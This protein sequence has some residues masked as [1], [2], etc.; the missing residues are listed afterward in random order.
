MQQ[1]QQYTNDSDWQQDVRPS[2][3]AYHTEPS[4]RSRSLTPQ[5]NQHWP[6]SYAGQAI[7]RKTKKKKN[8]SSRFGC[9]CGYGRP[10]AKRKEAPL[11]SLQSQSPCDKSAKTSSSSRY[12]YRCRY[13][14]HQLT[15]ICD[16][17]PFCLLQIYLIFCIF[18]RNYQ[19]S[20][21]CVIHISFHKV[22]SICLNLSLNTKQD[23]TYSNLNRHATEYSETKF[24]LFY[25][26]NKYIRRKYLVIERGLEGLLQFSMWQI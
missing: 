18:S 23:N 8:I 24:K 21:S 5:P 26:T 16:R 12:R 7:E 3:R 25:D 4:V 15:R 1:R 11:S 17:F 9:G 10:V 6:L 13:R 2:T 22:C 19:V 20:V 14:H